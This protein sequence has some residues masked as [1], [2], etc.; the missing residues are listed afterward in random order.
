MEAHTMCRAVSESSRVDGA[1]LSG[2]EWETPLYVPLAFC[3]NVRRIAER[4]GLTA[5]RGRDISI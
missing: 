3:K 2:N 1:H 4:L 5:A